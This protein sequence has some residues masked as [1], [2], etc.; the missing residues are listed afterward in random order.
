[1]PHFAVRPLGHDRDPAVLISL[2]LPFLIVML[3]KSE[4]LDALGPFSYARENPTHLSDIWLLAAL[5]S[6]TADS[7]FRRN[8]CILPK[9]PIHI[10]TV[11]FLTDC[12][13]K[14]FPLKK[15]YQSHDRYF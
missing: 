4:N 5:S 7:D 14:R 3:P 11:S 10:T 1:M 2:T 9:L 15:P 6:G 12:S 13:P 8:L